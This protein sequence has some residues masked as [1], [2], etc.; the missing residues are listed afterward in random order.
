MPC[1]ALQVWT[2]ILSNATFRLAPTQGSTRRDEQLVVVDRVKI[3]VVD[4]KLA[5]QKE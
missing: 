1:L 2:F 4:Q 3:V 5:P